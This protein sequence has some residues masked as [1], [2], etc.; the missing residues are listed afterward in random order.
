MNI[1]KLF[2][3]LNQLPLLKRIC[4]LSF[5]FGAGMIVIWVLILS[6][7]DYQGQRS[8]LKQC[9]EQMV[10]GRIDNLSEQVWRQ[11]SE[12][13][14]Q[15]LSS[16]KTVC[17]PSEY[18]YLS[19]ILLKI[20]L[21]NGS[22]IQVGKTLAQGHE[23]KLNYPL[24]YWKGEGA[25]AYW[26][27]ELHITQSLT[28]IY[29]KVTWNAIVQTLSHIAIMGLT[30]LMFLGLSYYFFI[31]QI[32]SFMID[33]RNKDMSGSRR[34]IIEQEGTELSQ[35]SLAILASHDEL[36]EKYLNLQSKVR[37]FQKE[38]DAAV[39]ASELKS[40]FLAKMSHELRTPLNGLLG[41]STLLLETKL[42]DEQR[43]YAQT[44]QVSLESFLY[45]VND[46]LDLSRI[47]SG[48]LNITSIPFSLR[49]VISGVSSL[50]KSRA[51]SKGLAFESRIGP[52]VPQTLRGD[53]V[54]IRQILI[55]LV[56]NVIQHTSKGYVLINL[57]PV[58]LEKGEISL[59]I[60]IEGSGSVPDFRDQ[61][62]NIDIVNSNSDFT[63][64]LKNKNSVGLDV[65][66]QI[67]ELMNTCIHHDSIENKGSTFWLELRLPII[68]QSYTK[69]FIDFALVGKLNVLVIDSYELSRKITL[70]LLQEWGIK[71]EVVTTAKEGIRIL[72]NNQLGEGGVNMVLCDDL[73]QDIAGVDACRRIREISDPLIRIVVLCSNPQLGDAEGFFL[74]GVNGFLSKQLRD[75]YLRSVMCQVFAERGGNSQ[76]RRLVTRYSVSDSENEEVKHLWQDT[77]P[78]IKVLVVEDNMVHQQ[79][80]MRFLEKKGFQ[81]DLA[82]NGFEAIELFKRNTFSIIFMDCLMPEMDG[83]ETTQIIREIEKSNPQKTR[84][85]IVALTAHAIDGEAERCFQVGMDEFITKPYKLAQLEMV[86]ERYIN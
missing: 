16:M 15:T 30:S 71:F 72:Q 3:E 38:R 14:A 82:S 51:E 6:T 76:E 64:E 40:Q 49:S 8:T 10:D 23:L 59:R 12:Q 47:E 2:R 18:S 63:P 4:F 53:P 65:C 62:E 28:G 67:A 85:P 11:D 35:L 27:G 46:I 86:L 50:L 24:S 73:L 25:Q 79:L 58:K 57:E 77:A 42:T 31:R 44:I 84:A 9:I 34:L 61:S 81:V 69:N 68:K 33:L 22:Q 29:S 37:I 60:S 17:L 39:K 36:D 20:E 1:R 75:P 70:E 74:S 13:V 26:L 41:F 54:R 32:K 7:L 80:I 66:Y 21:D 83:Y 5:C 19:P 78:K 48:D 52:E 55:N 45:V 56:S 43:E